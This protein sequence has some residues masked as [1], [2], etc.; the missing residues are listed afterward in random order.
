MYVDQVK[1]SSRTP[2]VSVLLHGPSGSGKTALAATIAMASEFPFIKLI[3]PE[4]MVGFSENAKMS[5]INKIFNDAYKSPLSVIM[6][7]CIERILEWVP[8]GPRFSNACLQTLLVLFKKPPPKGHKLLVI[9]TTTNRDVLNQMDMGD[10]FNAEILVHNIQ[11]LESLGKVT[12]ELEVF[13]ALD[14]ARSI[15]ILSRGGVGERMS[16]GVKKL[17][18]ICEM[19]KQDV[20]KVDKFVGSITDC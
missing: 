3:S 4:S 6:V 9:A 1:N 19:A 20:D 2:L 17:L 18:M 15:Q 5:H 10:A 11:D 13:S 14:L 16:L 7:D 8:I 12:K